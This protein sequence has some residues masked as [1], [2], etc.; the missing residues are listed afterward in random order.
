MYTY[1][2]A[3]EKGSPIFSKPGDFFT[4]IIFVG[5]IITVSHG[6]A[7][8][9]LLQIEHNHSM[10]RTLMDLA[11]FLFVPITSHICPP[12]LLLAAAVPGTEEDH[13]YS[14]YSPSF[15]SILFGAVSGAGM[16]G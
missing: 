16:V 10:E 8:L 1:S 2:S 9:D 12:S 13:P 11:F 7:G 6:V 14:L 4:Y 15:A 5:T 3:L